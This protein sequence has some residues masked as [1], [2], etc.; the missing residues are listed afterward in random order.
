MGV[1]QIISFLLLS[2]YFYATALLQKS[3]L[4]E[5][6]PERK[7]THLMICM[8]SDRGLCGG[9]HSSIAKAVRALM[10]ERE[11][12]SNTGL[13]LVGDKLRSVLQRTHRQN[14]LMAFNEIGRKPP[15]FTEASFIAQEIL[16]S[17]FEFDS[18][19]I[20]YNTFRYIGLLHLHMLSLIC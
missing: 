15:I 5:E 16:N 10:Q 14:I 9:I 7:S 12:N 19:E 3:E 20:V 13:V 1:A 4:V 11:A 2:I 17:G 8:T 18:A 6:D